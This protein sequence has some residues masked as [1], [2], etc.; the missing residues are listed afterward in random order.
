MMNGLVELRHVPL[1]ETKLAT[2]SPENFQQH[3]KPHHPYRFFCQILA[4]S[5]AHSICKYFLKC[6]QNIIQVVYF[7]HEK[8]IIL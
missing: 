7:G 8:S 2:P 4:N 3:K 5:T 1:L 6:T